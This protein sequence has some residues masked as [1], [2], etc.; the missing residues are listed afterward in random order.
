LP[1]APSLSTMIALPA[2]RGLCAFAAATA[3]AFAYDFDAV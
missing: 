2:G 3:V 1:S